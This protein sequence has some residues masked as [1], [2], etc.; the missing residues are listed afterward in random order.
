MRSGRG[1]EE[2]TGRLRS[3][4]SSGRVTAATVATQ[5]GPGGSN[6]SRGF[7]FVTV[8]TVEQREMKILSVLDHERII[9]IVGAGQSGKLP[10]NVVQLDKLLVE[11]AEVA[12]RVQHECGMSAA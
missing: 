11:V 8:T 9:K 5:K 7:G 1:A 2:W 3:G 4:G 6:L 12:V 10:E